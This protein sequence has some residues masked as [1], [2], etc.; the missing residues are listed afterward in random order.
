MA[1][2]D[3]PRRPPLR[4]SQG[5]TGNHEAGGKACTEGSGP[6]NRSIQRPRSLASSIARA[7][8]ARPKASVAAIVCCL[9]WIASGPL[10]VQVS[11]GHV[12]AGIYSGIVDVAVCEFS[13]LFDPLYTG[14]TANPR[15]RLMPGFTFGDWFITS[16]T[17]PLWI[18]LLCILGFVLLPRG[19]RRP[20]LPCA[21][22]DYDREGL[23]ATVACP[24]CGS[25]PKPR[26]GH[27]LD[28]GDQPASSDRRE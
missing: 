20:A 24:E 19:H 3:R 23:E 14:C 21:V 10:G 17:L 16:V 1:T 2:L 9:A 15:W 6:V 12:R 8:R 11:F 28:P 4:P 13:G 7:V 26:P 22:C 5:R 27:G 18:P 25:T